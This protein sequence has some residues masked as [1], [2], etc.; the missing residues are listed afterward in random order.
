LLKP[1]FRGQ[2]P[3]FATTPQR[4]DRAEGNPDADS[5]AASNSTRHSNS[6]NFN[7]AASAATDPCCDTASQFRAD[8]D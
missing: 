6:N 5:G 8:A 1:G 2:D 4:R 3:G 7:S